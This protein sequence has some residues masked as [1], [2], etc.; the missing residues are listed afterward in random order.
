MSF[1]SKES[2]NSI[3]NLNDII[4]SAQSPANK[5][6]LV[7]CRVEFVVVGKVNTVDE[8]FSATIKIRSKWNENEIINKYNPEYHWNPKIY[9]ENS[10]PEV[11]F[12][13]EA[14][15]KTN[16]HERGTEIVETRICKGNFENKFIYSFTNQIQNCFIQEDFGNEWNLWIFL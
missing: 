1:K 7:E 10:I 15:Y 11:N 9:V 3:V 16:T 4:I 2:I 12:F 13:Q 6:K 8:C 14:S 5:L